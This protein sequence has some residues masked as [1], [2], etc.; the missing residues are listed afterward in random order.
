MNVTA[1]V[2]N[3]NIASQKMFLNLGFQKVDEDEKT[4]NGFYYLDI[5]KIKE[6]NKDD[7]RKKY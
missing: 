3:Y 5:E 2:M 4:G 7:N 6:G 1:H